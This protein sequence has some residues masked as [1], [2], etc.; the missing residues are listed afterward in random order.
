MECR[1]ISNFNINAFEYDIEDEDFLNDVFILLNKM[2]EKDITHI[3]EY[4]EINY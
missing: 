2:I 4:V 3:F 1:Y